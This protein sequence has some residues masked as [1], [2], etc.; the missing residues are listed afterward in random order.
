MIEAAFVP[1]RFE[2]PKIPGAY[3]SA[4]CDTSAGRQDSM[5]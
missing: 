5:I 4:F 3:Y 2:L 1:K